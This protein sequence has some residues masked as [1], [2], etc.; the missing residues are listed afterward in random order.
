[1]EC[2][3][4]KCKKLYDIACLE[5]T[6]DAFKSYTEEYKLS[7]VC[8]ECMCL[9]PKRGN[10]GTPLIVKTVAFRTASSTTPVNNVNTKRGSQASFSPTL[11]SDT[12]LLE[13]IREFRAEMTARM[14]SQAEA[15]TL[16]LNQFSQTRSDL[17]NISKLMR[18]LEEKICTT[19]TEDILSNSADKS[20]S[21]TYANVVCELSGSNYNKKVQKSSENSTPETQKVN[22][23]GATKTAVSPIPV[24]DSIIITAPSKSGKHEQSKDDQ[25]NTEAGWITLKGRENYDDW[26]FAAENVLVLEGMADNIKQPL[27]STATEAQI[28][29]DLKAKAKLILTIDASLYT[30]E[31]IVANQTVVPV[32]CSGDLQLTTCVGNNEFTIDVNDVLKPEISPEGV[33]E[34][35]SD[36]ENQHDETYVPEDS[37]SESEDTFVDTMTL[38][39][40]AKNIISEN[41]DTNLP[42]KR[43]LWSINFVSSNCYA[44]NYESRIISRV[45]TY[46][47]DFSS[48]KI[49]QDCL[50]ALSAL[51]NQHDNNV[52]K[53]SSVSYLVNSNKRYK[54]GLI[55]AGESLLKSFF[56]TLDAEEALKFSNAIHQ[57]ETDEKQLAHLIR[58]NIHVIMSTITTFNNFISKLSENEQ[59]LN[60]N[61]EVIDKGL[62]LISN[63]NDNKM[64]VLHPT[65]ICLHQLYNE[66][67]Q[68]RNNMPRF[69]NS[70]Y[71]CLY[72]TVNQCK[73]IP[74]KFH[75]C[76]LES[77]FQVSLTQFTKD[78]FGDHGFALRHET[79]DKSPP[80][81][82]QQQST[83]ITRAGGHAVTRERAATCS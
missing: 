16:L 53:Y 45:N 31:I 35:D 71:P 23:G 57:V 14:N 68:N 47:K 67:E 83:Q 78:V 50:N 80:K 30:K 3:N 32:S 33:P 17:D 54:R 38:S 18:V 48:S 65:I 73:V 7:W 25:G 58:D 46:C 21:A 72:K 20:P 2:S 1:M 77:V 60:K 26:C 75:V 49:Q 39:P 9:M 44:N 13:E 79:F 6:I 63:S 64:N 11:S 27:P 40:E 76:E 81:S 29:D 55:D 24:T 41:G 43:A 52:K 34:S 8:P 56:G 4:G 62:Q 37:S 66:L 10:T 70:R 12:M 51:Q 28:A 59:R 22:K 36:E 19:Q 69:T 15:I 82:E 42:E 5:V 61:L 74:D